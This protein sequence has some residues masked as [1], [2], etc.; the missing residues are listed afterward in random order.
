VWSRRGHDAPFDEFM[1]MNVVMSRRKIP[2]LPPM[3]CKKIF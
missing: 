2:Y 1:V 3:H